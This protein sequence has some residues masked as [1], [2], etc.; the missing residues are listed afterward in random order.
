[1]PHTFDPSQKPNDLEFFS[2]FQPVV[3]ATLQMPVLHSRGNRPFQMTFEEHLRALVYF[4]LEEHHSAQHLLQVLEE[5]DFAR[6]AIAPKNGIKKSSFSEATNSRGL[7]QFMYV[8]QNLQAQASAILPKQNPELGDLVGIDGSLINATLSMHWADYRKNSKKAKVH[9]GF[10]L[11]QAIP[12][13][14][15][16]TDGNGAE[17]PFVSLILSDGQTGVM[18]RGYQSHKRFDQ[19]QQDGK[20]FMCRIKAST[21][22]TI[23]EQNH[24]ASDSI[25][26]FDAMVI[27]GTTQINQTQKTLRLVGY[28]VDRVK[29]WIA[30]NRYDL[31]AEQIAAA[32]KLRWDIENFFAWW[33]RHLKVYHLIARSEHGLMV[34]ILAG[35]ITY[36]L[37]AIYC[38]RQFNERVSIKRVRQLRIIIQNELRAGIFDKPPDSNLKEQKLQR[39][40]A[41]T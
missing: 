18:D 29:Y 16:L 20:L 27:L 5:D 32:Y 21:K 30:T 35:L 17:R 40:N 23:I 28:E 34:Q 10:D 11:N 31:T 14:I 41:K 36:L 38:H 8:Y 26:F 3:E 9:V 33:K 19:W 12:R 4:H 24:I 7:E 37:L 13:K 15:Y 2:F 39:V 25:I 6:S 1:M 22:K